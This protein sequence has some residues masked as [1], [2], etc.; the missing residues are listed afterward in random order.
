MRIKSIQQQIML[1]RV[2][3]NFDWPLNQ[4]WKGYIGHDLRYEFDD[5]DPKDGTIISQIYHPPAGTGYQIWEMIQSSGSP[6]TPVFENTEDLVEYIYEHGLCEPF[7]KPTREAARSFVYSEGVQ[8]WT[9]KDLKIL[10]PTGGKI[11]RTI[12]PMVYFFNYLEDQYLDNTLKERD[13]IDYN[14][15]TMI[16]QNLFSKIDNLVK[17][18]FKFK[19]EIPNNIP[20]ALAEYLQQRKLLFKN[21]PEVEDQNTSFLLYHYIGQLSNKF[22]DGKLSITDMLE[23]G[24]VINGYTKLDEKFNLL[25]LEITKHENNLPDLIL[26]RLSECK[27]CRQS[28]YKNIEKIPSKQ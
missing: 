21:L 6:I 2:P 5:T 12:A 14:I 9:Y 1:K 4:P 17:A 7:E 10:D 16:Y 18:I 19:D 25:W 22:L 8:V 13:L 27:E 11:S 24:Q 26:T 23:F 28:L 15:L 20:K 3:P